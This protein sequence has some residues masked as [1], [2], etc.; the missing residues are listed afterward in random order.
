MSETHR[1]LARRWFEEVW[2][3]RNP[4]TVDTLMTPDAMAHTEGGDLTGPAAFKVAR[5]LL[6]GAF[7]DLEVTVEDVVV[8]GPHAVVRWSAGGTHR[9]DQFGFPA[10]GREVRFRGMTWMRFERE[11]IVEGW[12]AWNLGAVLE[13]CRAPAESPSAAK[14]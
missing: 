1:A 6:L 5:A 4:D 8:E 13:A 7:P 10:S 14:A 11:R 9:G 2:N 3:K 12:D